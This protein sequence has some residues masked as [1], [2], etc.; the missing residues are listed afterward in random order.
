MLLPLAEITVQHVAESGLSLGSV[1]GSVIA[2]VASWERNRSIALAII[3][4]LLSWIYVIFFAITRRPN[5]SGP[6]DEADRRIS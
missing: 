5:E 3:A 4:G 2:V 1:L 6:R